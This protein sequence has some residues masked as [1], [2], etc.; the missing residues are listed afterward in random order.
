[1]HFADRLIEGIREKGTILICGIDP[2]LRYMPPHILRW[3]VQQF[4]PGMK[5]V[6]EVIVLYYIT[7]INVTFGK[8]LGYKPQIA[9][10]E[11]FGS[12]GI[13][14]LERILA[15]L[16]SL[17]AI[18]IL[19]AKREDGGDTSQAYASAYLGITETLDESGE[20][21]LIR[22]SCRVDAITITPWIDGP[23]IETFAMTAKE[24]NAGIFV[25][26]KTSFKPA[27]RLQD[28]LVD[29]QPAWVHLTEQVRDLSESEGMVGKSGYSLVGV[30]MGATYP[31]EARL[32]QQ[33]LPKSTK[34]VPGFGKGQGGRPDDAV[35]C[36]NNDGFGAVCNDSRGTNFAWHSKF[37]GNGDGRNYAVATLGA[38]EAG[39][40]ALNTAIEHKLGRMPW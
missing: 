30:V 22:P 37:G 39:T 4:G 8:V 20:I 35:I 9:F 26:D 5:A 28:V 10:F 32:M 31:E 27:S 17:D 34:L 21:V 11:K 38:V 14:A 3:A 25:V 29:G 18:V 24:N 15:Y 1:M 13:R 6:E 2:Q 7:I 23:N 12:H 33:L 19:D 16:G 40:H 36:V